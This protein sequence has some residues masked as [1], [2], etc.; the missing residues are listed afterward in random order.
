M[1]ELTESTATVPIVL[2]QIAREAVALSENKLQVTLTAYYQG[3]TSSLSIR[4]AQKDD[5]DPHRIE[6]YALHLVQGLLEKYEAGIAKI[7][8]QVKVLV[9]TRSAEGAVALAGGERAEVP[10]EPIAQVVDTTGAGDLF[11]AGFLAGHARG[12]DLQTCLT[13]GAICAREIISHYGA[14]PEEDLKALVA[15]RL[16]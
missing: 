6:V 1:G 12:R 3:D 11:A 10:A 4:N 5:R 14:R 13:M 2:Y 16:G 15:A 7:A 9:V 8:P